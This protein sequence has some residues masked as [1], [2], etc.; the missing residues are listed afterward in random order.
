MTRSPRLALVLPPLV[1]AGCA[2]AAPTPAEAPPAPPAPAATAARPATGPLTPP[3]QQFVERLAAVEPALAEQPEQAVGRG[4]SICFG[5]QNGLPEDKPA[6]NA[7]E[8]F[9]AGDR[10]L[11]E[12]DAAQV[13]EAA[14]ETLCAAT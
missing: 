9:T 3:E 14:R 5:L 4:E 1:P 2:G 12:A 6:A 8:R 10:R 11:S 13:V 7:V